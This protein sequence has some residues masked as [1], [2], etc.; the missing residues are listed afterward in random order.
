L[1]F[2]LVLAPMTGPGDAVHLMRVPVKRDHVWP[3]CA[4]FPV[5]IAASALG[6]CYV[7]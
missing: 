2:R 4:L 1:L 3:T 5:F 7:Q 6:G